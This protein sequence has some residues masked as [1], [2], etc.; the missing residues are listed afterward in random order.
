[1]AKR[2]SKRLSP[3]YRNPFH[4]HPLLHKG[5]VHEKTYKAKRRDE[6]VQL[7]KEWPFLQK[8]LEQSFI[9]YCF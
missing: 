5:A 1:M 2:K 8:F 6:K 9:C 3:M 4:D 7:K